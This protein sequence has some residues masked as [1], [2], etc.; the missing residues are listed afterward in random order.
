MNASRNWV[1]SLRVGS[2]RFTRRERAVK[3]IVNR[4]FRG[5][6]VSTDCAES[7]P[8]RT[9]SCRRRPWKSIEPARRTARRHCGVTD[10]PI[11]SIWS[12]SAQPRPFYRLNHASTSGRT[13]P[14]RLFSRAPSA[15]RQFLWLL[16]RRLMRPDVDTWL[17]QTPTALAVLLV[18][19]CYCAAAFSI[20]PVRARLTTSNR[21]NL[22]SRNCGCVW[23]HVPSADWV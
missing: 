4:T 22:S 1:D 5:A 18:L 19:Y 21:R 11:G 6:L 7:G 14:R 13:R 16:G 8:A 2:V 15:C 9:R 12:G 20:G 23:M 10:E 3:R 17:A